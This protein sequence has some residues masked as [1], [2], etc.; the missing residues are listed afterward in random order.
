MLQHKLVGDLMLPVVHPLT[1]A[2]S[3]SQAVDRILASGHNGLPVLDEH[4]A[5]IGFLSEHDCLSYLISSSYHCDSRVQVQDIMHRE[6]LCVA[7]GDSMI[8]L[9]Q[10]MSHNRPKSYPV[11]AHGRLVGLITRHQLMLEL[12]RM[13]RECK[14]AI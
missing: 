8:D 6:P 2:M 4:Q 1:G 13:L 3:L 12:N 11:V 7:P 9:A 14:V 5:V 10:Q